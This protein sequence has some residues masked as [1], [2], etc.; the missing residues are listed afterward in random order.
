MTI[1][2]IKPIP[3]TEGAYSPFFSPDGEWVAFFADGKLKKAAP[4]SG[5]L[6]VLAEAM[7]PGG[8]WGDDIHRRCL[9]FDAVMLER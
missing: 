2:E 1:A 8:S 9:G 5:E 3:G 4:A 6:V 7:G